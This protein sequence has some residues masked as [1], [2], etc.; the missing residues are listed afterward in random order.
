ME[1]DAFADGL[2]LVGGKRGVEGISKL[3]PEQR[4]KLPCVRLEGC[5][6]SGMERQRGWNEDVRHFRGQ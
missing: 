3:F 2:H 1:P 4:M 5:R 6:Q